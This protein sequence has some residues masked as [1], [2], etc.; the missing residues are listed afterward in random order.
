MQADCPGCS[1]TWSVKE[2]FAGRTI[3]CPD[4]DTAWTVEA[5]DPLSAPV[6]PLAMPGS[7]G[8]SGPSCPHCESRTLRP[9]I[10]GLGEMGCPNCKGTW[11]EEAGVQRLASEVLKIDPGILSQLEPYSRG[12]PWKCPGCG[13]G[14][15]T[16]QLRNVPVDRCGSCGGVWM[17]GGEFYKATGG[18]HGEQMQTPTR[19]AVA[20]EPEHLQV[21]LEEMVMPHRRLK[22]RQEREW[23]EILTGWE[24]ANRYAVWGGMR[25]VANVLE[26]SEGLEA[27]LLRQFLGSHRPLN[28]QV[29]DKS[30]SQALLRFTR[31]FFWFFS[32]MEVRTSVGDRRLGRVQRRFR[33]LQRWYDLHD[34]TGRLFA[35]IRSPL[36]RFW[37]FRI[38]D[39]AGNQVGLISKKWSGLLQEAVA[40]AD[41]FAVDFGS[42]QW[43][44]AQRCVLFA[45]ALSIDF[46]YFENNQKR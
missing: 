39:R 27:A 6:I 2:K 23:V 5:F 24:T 33:L 3:N 35:T 31:P 12:E 40:D 1:K 25:L 42:H 41:N 46:D 36:L 21:A 44:L 17:D 29:L 43:S 11:L 13:D 45:A 16:I 32:N 22:I 26:K 20:G 19:S 30:A 10:E 37:T 7:R 14:M 8:P 4:C 28:V 38:H 15:A 18:R 9:G 34:E